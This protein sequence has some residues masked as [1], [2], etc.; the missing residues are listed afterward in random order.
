MIFKVFSITTVILIIAGC[1]H[2]HEIP[3]HQHDLPPHDHAHEHNHESITDDTVAQFVSASYEITKR[4]D[5]HPHDIFSNWTIRFDKQPNQLQITD[6]QL[7]VTEGLEYQLLG[8][9]LH[10]TSTQDKVVVIWDGGRKAF[11]S[12]FT[13]SIDP[14]PGSTILSEHQFSLRFNPRGRFMQETPTIATVTLNDKNTTKT[15]GSWSVILN[16]PKGSHSLVLKWSL[17]NGIKGSQTF[18]PYIVEE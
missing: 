6:Y 17:S 10:V 12:H 4:P 2:E 13:P 9:N 16:L 3:T 5:A 11:I 18:E 7:Q 8:A 14:H 1:S 15:E